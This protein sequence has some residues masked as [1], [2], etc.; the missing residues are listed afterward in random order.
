MRA[1][2]QGARCTLLTKRTEVGGAR[3]GLRHHLVLH[4]DLHWQ[5]VV[6]RLEAVA[7]IGIA[8]QR[9]VILEALRIR[10]AR[11]GEREGRV[12]RERE[13]GCGG[14][15]EASSE[16][17]SEMRTPSARARAP[18]RAEFIIRADDPAVCV[19]SVEALRPLCG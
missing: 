15:R 19:A 9:L 11:G 16:A 4:A 5:R 13:R 12:S 8:E 7:P 3:D 2:N 18:E 10:A 6:R 17:S 1:R 14:G